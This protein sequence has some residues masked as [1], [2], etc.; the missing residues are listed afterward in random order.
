MKVAAWSLNMPLTIK[1]KQWVNSVI[2]CHKISCSAF[3]SRLSLPSTTKRSCI[4]LSCRCAVKCSALNRQ[5][6]ERYIYQPR[7]SNHYHGQHS[8]NTVRSRPTNS[9]RT[10]PP[11][12]N[13]HVWTCD[14]PWVIRNERGDHVKEDKTNYRAN[15]ISRVSRH[16]RCRMRVV[17]R[18]GKV[19]G[20]REH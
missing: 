13:W 15:I 11:G 3:L 18:L 20:S 5:K 14:H 4:P 9:P 10:W 7:W 1:K 12:E 8:Q 17:I 19:N 6:T 2:W 16:F